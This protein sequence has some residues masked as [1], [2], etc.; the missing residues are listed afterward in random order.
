M[1]EPSLYKGEPLQRTEG[2]ATYGWE[3]PM[4]AMPKFK[5]IL[6]TLVLPNEVL[7]GIVEG[8]LQLVSVSIMLGKGFSADLKINVYLDIGR[9]ENKD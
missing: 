3:T 5:N 8:L 4:L 7:L 1:Y 6:V 9:T 2:A